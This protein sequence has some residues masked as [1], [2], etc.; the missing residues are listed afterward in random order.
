MVLLVCQGERD[1]A[2]DSDRDVKQSV[3]EQ[4]IERDGG[5]CRECNRPTGPPHHIIPKSM[6]PGRLKPL[7]DQPKNL[8][9]LC[10]EHHSQAHTKAARRRHLTM[11]RERY[12]YVYDSQPWIGAL[13]EA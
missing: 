13:G 9:C 5:L 6:L 12:N 3:C 2:T 7:R 8:I 11:L 4:V 1:K 10:L